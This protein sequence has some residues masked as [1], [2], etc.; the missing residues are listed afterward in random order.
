L[1]N[2]EIFLDRIC[3]R[4]MADSTSSKIAAAEIST[5]PNSKI[6]K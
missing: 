2:F 1:G 5:F 6:S 3:L 4:Y